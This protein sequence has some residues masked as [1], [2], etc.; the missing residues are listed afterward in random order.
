LIDQLVPGHAS[1]T[2]AEKIKHHDFLK[3]LGRQRCDKRGHH[4]YRLFDSE[5]G[6]SKDDIFSSSFLGTLAGVERW[7]RD[8]LSG[9]HV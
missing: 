5:Q 9:G 6:K 4:Q 7:K 1:S 2:W 3:F 8:Y